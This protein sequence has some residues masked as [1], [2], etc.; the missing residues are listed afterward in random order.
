MT[1]AAKPKLKP[2]IIYLTF[3]R[4]V[5][6]SIR[7][8]GSTAVYTGRTTDGYRLTKVTADDIREWAT[9][10]MGP[11]HCECGTLTAGNTS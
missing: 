1:A 7:C 11:L 9:Y 6:A 5:C 3:D 2:G 8:A 10:D 4:F